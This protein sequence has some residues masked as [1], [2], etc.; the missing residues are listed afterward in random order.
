MPQ[1]FMQSAV[2][3]SELDLN[4]QRALERLLT[5]RRFRS[6]GALCSLLK[7]LGRST[8]PLS[9]TDLS[10]D[11]YGSADHEKTVRAN[12]W[13]LREELERYYA[14]EG[15]GDTVRISVTN[16]PYKLTYQPAK[17]RAPLIGRHEQSCKFRNMLSAARSGHGSVVAIAGEAGFGKTMLLDSIVAEGFTTGQ[18]WYIGRGGCSE[19][20]AS[21]STFFVIIDALHNLNRMADDKHVLSLMSRLAPTWYVRIE[22]DELGQH[23]QDSSLLMSTRA[24]SI[25]RLNREFLAFLRAVSEQSPTL[26]IL[27]DLH[28]AD[29]ATFELITYLSSRIV[30]DRILIAIAYRPSDLKRIR[31]SFARLLVDMKS[32]RLCSELQLE[33]FGT[34]EIQEALSD[35]CPGISPDGSMTSVLQ[36]ITGGIP[37]F[38]VDVIRHLKENNFLTPRGGE[39]KLSISQD[40]I[41]ST[42]PASISSIVFHR[43]DELD[44]TERLLLRIASVQGLEFDSWLIAR[45]MS[46]DS[47]QVEERLQIISDRHTLIKLVGERT[48]RPNNTNPNVRYQF[49]HA[50]YQ[51]ALFKRVG[52]THR[53]RYSL[54]LAEAYIEIG[55]ELSST[56]AVNVSIL[57][58]QG[59]DHYRAARYMLLAAQ[60]GMKFC[61]SSVTVEQL[62]RAQGMLQRQYKNDAGTLEFEIL[63]TLGACHMSL[64]GYSSQQAGDAYQHSY[65]LGHRLDLGSNLATPLWGLWAF[66]VTRGHSLLAKELA[67]RTLEAAVDSGTPA[68]KM[69]AFYAAGITALHGGEFL[70]ARSY[71]SSGVDLHERDCGRHDFTLYLF[72][73]GVAC[74]SHLARCLWLIG[75]PDAGLAQAQRALGDAK[76]REHPQTIAYAHIFLSLTFLLRRNYHRAA[77]SAQEALALSKTHGFS[78][79][80]VWAT[81]VL[82]ACLSQLGDPREG[83][84][85]ILESI[86]KQQARESRVG[87]THMAIMLAESFI[88]AGDFGSALAAVNSGLELAAAIGET[89][90]EPELLRIKGEVLARTLSGQIQELSAIFVDAIDRARRT[91][92]RSLELRSLVSAAAYTKGTPLDEEIKIGLRTLLTDVKEGMDTPDIIAAMEALR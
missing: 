63:N 41:V 15:I 24:A 75:F 40:Q 45:A 86:Q 5:S 46:L 3:H 30:D 18:R 47:S 76:S 19:Q 42:L 70:S 69:A 31:R 61:A 56:T 26:L 9:Q 16:G 80:L 28:W 59:E 14:E 62:N 11:L 66:H 64:A 81:G 48:L 34:A 71:F 2:R 38:V 84:P 51:Q 35:T 50:L 37:L 13:R 21:A 7:R 68:S 54:A 12:V 44:D 83:I 74:R 89:L 82:G 6:R 10:C 90:M 49:E 1:S 17:Q 58:E 20:L 88:C 85:M 22:T 55:G 8:E 87:G 92:A 79:E 29:D 52:P 67:K 23:S 78:Q 43:L 4:Q 25:A 27:D 60:A 72:D 32:K 39:W 73:P 33:P 91:G 77:T 36:A 65:D 57:F 53:R